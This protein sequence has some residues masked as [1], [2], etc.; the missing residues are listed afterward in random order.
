MKAQYIAGRLLH[1]ILVLFL[2]YLLLRGL[3]YGLT[4][5]KDDMRR[6]NAATQPSE[7]TGSITMIQDDRP[8]PEQIVS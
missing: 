6:T 7:D 4:L 8:S 5:L 1:I 3:Y 2:C